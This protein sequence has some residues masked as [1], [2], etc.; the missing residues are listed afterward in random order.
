MPQV[1]I[2]VADLRQKGVALSHRAI[3]RRA[4]NL[5]YALPA[6]RIH[7]DQGSIWKIKRDYIRLFIERPFLPT[8]RRRRR[9]RAPPVLVA[10]GR[11]WWRRHVGSSLPRG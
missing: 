11:N 7:G 6:F 1:F 8:R 3:N 10:A 5:F 9:R 4:K 2:A